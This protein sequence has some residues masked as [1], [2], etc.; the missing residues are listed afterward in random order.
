MTNF[1]DPIATALRAARLLESA[2]IRY[3]LYGG[4]AVA[5]WGVARETKDADLAVV[6]ASAERLVE[7]LVRDGVE[8]RTAFDRVPFGGL[9][10]SRA[11]LF[12]SGD[13]S[14]LN[15]V[16]LVEPASARYA[17]A[18]LERVLRAPLRDAEIFLLAP[19]DVVIFKL[20][21]TR[22][23]DVEDAASIL[24]ALKDDIRITTIDT[25]VDRLSREIPR[26]AVAERWERCR[27]R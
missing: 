27:A 15:T 9:V 18:A 2:D 10:V 25:E 8:A 21:S 26:H 3:G 20:L 16:D 11:T 1:D 7:L 19:E 24:H 17:G 23:K 13:D 5:A 14:G 22:D 12:G 4:L 6:S